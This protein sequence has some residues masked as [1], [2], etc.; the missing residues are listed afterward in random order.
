MDFRDHYLKFDNRKLVL[1]AFCVNHGDVC[2]ESERFN[3]LVT[4]YQPLEN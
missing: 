3:L 2:A 4:R 1:R